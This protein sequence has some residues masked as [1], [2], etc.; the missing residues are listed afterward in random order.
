MIVKN[1]AH[2]IERC[3]SSVLPLIDHVLLVDTGST[4]GTQAV[5]RRYLDQAGIPGD[6]ID[7]AWRDFAYNR[8]FALAK[9]REHAG[10]DYSLMIDADQVI[11]FDESF[12]FKKFKSALQYD[13]YDVEISSGN[14]VYLQPQLASNKID[15]SYRGVLHEFREFPDGCRRGL[16]EGLQIK[17]IHDSARGQDPL[18]YQK[19]AAIFEQ[20]LAVETDPLLIARYRY[21][22][23]Q[24]YRDAGRPELAIENYLKRSELGFWDEEVFHSLYSAAKLKETLNHPEEDVIETYLRAHRVCP[25]RI[26]AIHGA[27]R[28]CRNKGRHDQGYRLAKRFLH[29]PCPLSGLFIE[30][31]I[32]D[33]GLLDEFSV[34]AF[35]SGRYA[36]CLEAC[37]RILSEK[38]LPEEECVRIR[39]NAHFAIEKLGTNLPDRS[40]I[41]T[42]IPSFADAAATISRPPARS[43]RFAIV[44]PYYKEDRKTLERCLNSVRTQSVHVDHIVVADGFPQLWID[45]EP[46]R[47][48]KLDSA[49][50][51]FGGTPRGLGLLLAVSEGY[52]AIGLLDADNWIAPDHVERCLDLASRIAERCDFV[53]ARRYFMTPKEVSL[54][55]PDEPVTDLVDT[56]CYFFFSGSYPALHHWVTMPKQLSPIGDRIFLAATQT[57]K[58]RS[59]ML[60]QATVFYE[61]LWSSSYE[62]R[63]LPV[64]ENAKLDIDT[65]SITSWLD[66]LTTS[67]LHLVNRLSGSV[68][69]VP[70]SSDNTNAPIN[71]NADCP[72]G[73][74][75]RYKHCHGSIAN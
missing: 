17:E 62:S 52:E 16:A 42:S 4:D 19:D 32:F 35:W 29:R 27:A 44:T 56:N 50:G 1:E 73:S 28:F 12:D 57:Y 70:K 41:D 21:Y 25:A 69:R 74:G 49:H 46:V 65:A 10:I 13:L 48:L 30:K 11:V 40:D 20:A 51:D 54:G 58:L 24:S 6:I 67:E 2:I 36:E 66:S 7:E 31:W 64:P 75:K 72:C 45:D 26:E 61:T 34:L 68:I 47:H 59:A 43:S 22:L 71:R 18:K 60:D 63:G 5:A 23:A 38:K 8:S 14:V 39:Q 55:A 9:L 37:S 3:L 53:V 33:F 15:V